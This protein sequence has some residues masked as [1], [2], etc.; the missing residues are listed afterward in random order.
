M[1]I[2]ESLDGRVRVSTLVEDSM[3]PLTAEIT[4]LSA[5]QMEL[6]EGMMIYAS[7]KTTEARAY[8]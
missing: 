8:I 3:L 2:D 7:F 5:D 1:D 6:R 4:S